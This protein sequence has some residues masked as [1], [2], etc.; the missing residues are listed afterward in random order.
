MLS[1]QQ[2]V[3]ADYICRLHEYAISKRVKSLSPRSEND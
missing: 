1:P 3:L 2:E